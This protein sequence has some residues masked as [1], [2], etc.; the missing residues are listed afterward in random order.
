M[1]EI[2]TTNYPNTAKVLVRSENKSRT[3]LGIA[4][5]YLLIHPDATVEQL[6]QA[7]PGSK[8]GLGENKMFLGPKERQEYVDALKQHKDNEDPEKSL[9]T[10]YFYEDI[11]KETGQ[12]EM[13]VLKNGDTVA[14]RQMWTEAMLVQLVE[15]AKQH[16]I[17]VASFEEGARGKRGKFE[18]EYLNNWKPVVVEKIVE[19]EV[20]REVE[21]KHIPWWVWLLLALAIVGIVLAL[22]C[23]PKAESQ[24][25]TVTDTVVQTVVDTVYI[26]KLE[27]IEDNFNAA[28][29]QKDKA[30]LSEDAKFVLHD[31][32][33]LMKD[34]PELRLRIA[35][36]TSAEGDAAHN[37]KLS[38]ARAQTAVTFLTEHEGI[39]ASRLEAAG[40]GS[41]QPKN[42]DD[43]M[44]PEN[45]RTEFEII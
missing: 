31:L 2:Q 28:E 23:R 38:E 16:D 18:L 21:K 37:Q 3:A 45:R 14:V 5:A 35:G 8:V 6:N 15:C 9:K 40:F 19:K 41:S 26:Q 42:A 10:N 34:Y 39:D 7:F 29:F 20:V 11:N 13:L 12:S 43:P 44:A 17:Y 4:N 24:V 36:H 22:L 27:Q 25:V 1:S 33:K 32:A 30:D